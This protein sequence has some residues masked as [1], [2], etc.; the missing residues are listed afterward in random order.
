MKFMKSKDQEI[1]NLKKEVARYK[2][3]ALQACDLLEIEDLFHCDGSLVN[4]SLMN[5]YEKELRKPSYQK[6]LKAK[7]KLFQ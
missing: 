4:F 7:K 1:K 6:K 2:K 3:L 5:F